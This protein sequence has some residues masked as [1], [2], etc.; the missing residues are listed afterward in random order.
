MRP[1]DKLVMSVFHVPEDEFESIME[2]IG[3][4]FNKPA[5][6]IKGA[7]AWAFLNVYDQ[8]PGLIFAATFAVLFVIPLVIFM[9]V[10]AY[11]SQ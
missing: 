5:V 11:F 3:D 8:S 1:I 4:E 2:A 10:F 7:C 9:N 6:S